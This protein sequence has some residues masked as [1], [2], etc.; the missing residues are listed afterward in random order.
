M[1]TPRATL[2]SAERIELTLSARATIAVTL[3][4]NGRLLGK[5]TLRGGPGPTT[6]TLRT[7]GRRVLAHGRYIV[8]FTVQGAPLSGAT[9][10]RVSF[11]IS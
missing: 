2:R 1:R 3:T 7:I 6:V 5:T 11:T 8:A 10:R 9:R 4:R